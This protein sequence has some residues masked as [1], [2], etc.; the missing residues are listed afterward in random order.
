MNRIA[1]TGAN[2][3]LGA[4]LCKSLGEA[5]IPLT[6][7]ELDLA[8]ADQIER[9]LSEIQPDFVINAA[10]YT[11]VD[12]AEDEIERCHQINA[13]AVHTLAD[14]CQRFGATLVQISTDYVFD[15]VTVDARNGGVPH[16]EADLAEPQGVYA[17]SKL[18]GESYAR[19]CDRHYVVRTCGL[20]SAVADSPVRGRNFVDTM[21]S[22]GAERNEL[23]IVHDQRCTPTFV[24]HLV[25]AIRFLMETRQYGTYHIT[26]SDDATWFEFAGEL[27]RQAKIDVELTPI[28]TEAYG[29]PAPRP[30]YSVLDNAKY[31]A[32]GG[33]EMPRWSSAL[34]EYLATLQVPTA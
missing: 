18:A 21:L 33:P 2:G 24:P 27:F 28:T 10:A 16:Q 1:V 34:T 9:V 15:S 30:Q 7:N 13:N 8:D 11:A 20:Y 29:A 19:N 22:L 12:K 23:S 6:R 31:L 14:A 26:N 4:E 25:N 3:Q 17:R 32:L 5:V